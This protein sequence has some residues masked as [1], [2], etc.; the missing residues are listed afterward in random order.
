MIRINVEDYGPK[1]FGGEEEFNRIR[2]IRNG[3]SIL[4]I[5]F[6]LFSEIEK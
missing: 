2:V 3:A 1:I 6:I 4:F 5:C